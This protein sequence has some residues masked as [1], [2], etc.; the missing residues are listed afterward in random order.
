MPK[1]FKTKMPKGHN[2]V[3]FIYQVIFSKPY[4]SMLHIS[5]IGQVLAEQ[6]K[7]SKLRLRAIFYYIQICSIVA[8]LECPF[9]C[10]NPQA[11]INNVIMRFKIL[12]SH[13]I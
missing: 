12:C 5:V 7:I 10:H 1:D 13:I 9:D 8:T 3:I 4:S 2:S 11:L 6:N